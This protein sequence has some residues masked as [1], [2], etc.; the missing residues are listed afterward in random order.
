MSLKYRR[1]VAGKWWLRAVAI[2]LLLL[3]PVLISGQK[4]MTATMVADS[5]TGTKVMVLNY[6]KIDNTFISLAVRSDDFEDQMRYLR[7]NGYHT[8]SPDELYAPIC[9]C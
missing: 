4:P 3:V 9:S 8:I 6:H 7:D 1:K 5:E 2:L